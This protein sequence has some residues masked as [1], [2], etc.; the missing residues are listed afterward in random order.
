MQKSDFKLGQ[1]LELK[2][3][4]LGGIGNKGD[5]VVLLAKL[6]KPVDGWECIVRFANGAT[7]GFLEKDL[8]LATKTLDRIVVVK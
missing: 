3:D 6:F 2:H 1:Y 8:K 5:K 4:N 7:E